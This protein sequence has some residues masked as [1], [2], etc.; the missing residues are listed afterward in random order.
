VVR[1]QAV[2]QTGGLAIDRLAESNAAAKVWGAILPQDTQAGAFVLGTD[3]LVSNGR[4][5]MGKPSTPQEAADM[6]A[7]LAGRTHVVVSG[8]ALAR[9]GD[10]SGAMDG[11]ASLTVASASTEVTFAKLDKDQID[12]YVHTGEWR[13]KA[14]GYAVQGIAGLFV[15]GIKGE[16][17]NVV[18][19]PLNLMQGLFREL[20][21]DLLR[22]TW[23]EGG[24]GG[25][26]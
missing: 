5:I 7:A 21:F 13:G 3:T 26:S 19:L 4:R 25:R 1:S 16:Y 24:R 23:T 15:R 17:S 22:R 14:G 6:L 2:E 10:A 8:V 9:V 12:A 20:G 11:N 18:G